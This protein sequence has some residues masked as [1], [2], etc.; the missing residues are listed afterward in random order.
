[1]IVTVQSPRVLCWVSIFCCCASYAD[2][3]WFEMKIRGVS[4]A[5]SLRLNVPRQAEHLRNSSGTRTMWDVSLI[6][7][8]MIWCDY[9]QCYLY[10]S[11]ILYAV[12]LARTFLQQDIVDWPAQMR[13]EKKRPTKAAWNPKGSLL[14]L[15]PRSAGTPARESGQASGERAV[16]RCCRCALLWILCWS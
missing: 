7:C 10:R 12:F 16:G 5:S 8:C 14:Q 1:M 9:I 3:W 15:S 6:V 13:V 11:S 4:Q 2:L